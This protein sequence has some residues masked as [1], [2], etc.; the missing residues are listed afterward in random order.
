MSD[1]VVVLLLSLLSSGVSEALSYVL[2]YRTD[3]FQRLKAKVIQSEIKLEQEKQA[4]SSGKG[5][6]RQRRIESIE[7]QLSAARSKAGS[8]QMRNMLVVGLVQVAA[9]YLVNARFSGRVVGVLPFEPVS[10]FRGL[11]HRGLAEDAPTNACSA[12]FIFV[13]GGLMF[14]A[15]ADRTLQLGLPKG[16]SLPQWVTNP[17]EVIGG[18]K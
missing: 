5:K 6:Q 2:V 3:D 8:M 7:A 4:T 18:K 16:S 14:R 1:L 9:I 11:T 17:E 10:M 12:T 15:L 13:L